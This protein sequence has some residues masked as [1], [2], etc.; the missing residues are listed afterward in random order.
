ME[1]FNIIEEKK[2]SLFKRREVKFTINAE[3]TPSHS[4]ARKIITEKFSTAKE[5]IRIKKI[6]GKFGSKSF[7]ISAHIYNSEQDKLSTEGQ[8]KKD[9][10]K[11]PEK[12]AEE[13]KPVEEAV[14]VEEPKPVEQP[15]PEAQPEP[16]KVPEEKPAEQP[17]EVPQEDAN[18][19]QDKSNSESTK[20]EEPVSKN[21]EESKPEEKT[22]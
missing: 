10:I 21:K 12:P 1:N 9:A 3:I 16:A 8:S 15:A 20:P 11:E 17:V 13:P 7:T 19:S 22:E 2:N 18:V 14:S 5:N 4:D 6:L